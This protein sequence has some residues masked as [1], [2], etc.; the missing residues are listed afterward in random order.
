M[1]MGLGAFKWYWQRQTIE[2]GHE[3]VSQYPRLIFDNRGMGE[4]DK[5][6]MRYSRSE[7]AKDTLE[8]LNHLGWT[9]KRSAHRSGMSMDDMVIQEMVHTSGRSVVGGADVGPG[10]S[11]PGKNRQSFAA[12]NSSTADK[13]DCTSRELI[14]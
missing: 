3:Q 9:G 11:R 1:I 14:L 10:L 7:M 2:I 13:H 8:M 4:S 12:A 5:P 6:V